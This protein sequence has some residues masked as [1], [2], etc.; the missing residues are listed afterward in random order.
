GRKTQYGWCVCGSLSS[1]VDP[2]GNTTTWL[3]D[4]EGRVTLKKYAD[5]T[6]ISYVYES[7]TSR[8]KS[9]TDAL[10]QTM[11]YTYNLD[12]TIAQISYTNAVDRNPH[13]RPQLSAHLGRAERLGNKFLQLQPVHRGSVCRA[14]YRWWQTKSS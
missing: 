1:L 3:Y 8:L 12:D 10:N 6:T 13:V 4:L 11:N 7:A 5:N 9:R 2:A 14:D